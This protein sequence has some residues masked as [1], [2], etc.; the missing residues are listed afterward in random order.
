MADTTRYGNVETLKAWIAEDPTQVLD[1]NDQSMDVLLGSLLDA[2]SRRIDDDCGRIFYQQTATARSY[3]PGRT[4]IVEVVDLLS[5]TSIVIDTDGDDIVETT[6][7][8]TDYVLEPFTEESGLG[9][10]RYQRIRSSLTGGYKFG[11]RWKVTV[12][13]SWGYVDGQ[14]RAPDSIRTAAMILA[15]R[16]F[17]RRHAKFGR[18]VIPESGMTETLPVND[19]DYLML[20]QPY[21]HDERVMNFA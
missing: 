5:V 2:A 7:A 13:G 8:T 15:S 6:M 17:M 3:Y 9:A 19:P 12:T 10:A 16:W 20:I 18:M 4:G 11:Y 1:A 14:G 21:I